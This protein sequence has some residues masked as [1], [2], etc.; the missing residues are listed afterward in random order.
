MVAEESISHEI[1]LRWVPLDL[2]DD[3]S[4]LVQGMAW[5]HQATSH[6]LSQRWP[7]SMSPNGV[8]RPQ[9]VKKMGPLRHPWWYYF[10]KIKEP[11]HMVKN[12]S[13][14]DLP[15]LSYY[16]PSQFNQ[17]QLRNPTNSRIKFPYFS[18]AILKI[19]LI[20]KVPKKARANMSQRA[21]HAENVSIW[22]CHHEFSDAPGNPFLA[23]AFLNQWGFN[24][25]HSLF[26]WYDS[27][28][29]PTG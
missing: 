7:R 24:S 4:T 29:I 5:C 26:L 23:R 1:A 17:G 3:K 13:R 16:K 6:Y 28:L 8:T 21:S 2:T 25:I 22:W 9:W 20:F 18:K 12:N 14:R 10:N 11:A 27:A 19:S 15:V